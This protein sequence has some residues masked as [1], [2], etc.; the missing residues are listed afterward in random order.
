M[1]KVITVVAKLSLVLVCTSTIKVLHEII[2]QKE[3][4]LFGHIYPGKPPFRDTG[5]AVGE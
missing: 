4:E 1:P 2:D 3:G 5:L